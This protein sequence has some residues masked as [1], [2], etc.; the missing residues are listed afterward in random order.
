ME[1]V[2][3]HVGRIVFYALIYKRFSL[4][5][6]AN[7]LAARAKKMATPTAPLGTCHAPG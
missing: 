7:I 6:S 4:P 1:D 3:C 5:S 2:S